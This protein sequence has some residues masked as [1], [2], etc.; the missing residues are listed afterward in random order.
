MLLV[1]NFYNLNAKKTMISPLV[2]ENHCF[3]KTYILLSNKIVTGPSF[4]KW[5]AIISP[6]TPVST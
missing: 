4:T 1:E 3:D 2:E 5:T 6:K